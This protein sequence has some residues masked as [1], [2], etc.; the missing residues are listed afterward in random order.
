MSHEGSAIMS[1]WVRVR[2]SASADRSEYLVCSGC[3]T[4]AFSYRYSDRELDALYTDYRGADYFALR[5]SWEPSYGPALNDDLGAST[6]VVGARQAMLVEALNGTVPDE[7]RRIGAVIDIGGDRGQFIPA[8]FPRRFVM[9]VSGKA[10]VD[11]VTP[12][13][14]VAEARA[15]SADLLMV[16]GLLEHLP[17]P[18]TFLSTA[19]DDL[20]PDRSVLVYVE[21]PAGV[22]DPASRRYPKTALAAG[23]LAS[24]WRPAWAALDRLDARTRARR[25][26]EF[27]LMPLRQ[28]EHINFFTTAGVAALSQRLGW[29]VLLLDEYAMPSRLLEG[30]RLGFS[31]VL[32]GLLRSQIRS[33]VERS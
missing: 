2:I 13:E 11:G 33:S 5:H 26:R 32:R 31:R 20:A 6:E 8:V 1:P 28:S 12:V 25:S 7:S 21:V 24:R 4:G 19:S 27:A 15:V 3:G 23:G 29:D 18:T 10:P 9:E 17:D 30:G 22:P 14:T 16:C